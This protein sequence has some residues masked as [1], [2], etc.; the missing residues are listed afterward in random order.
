MVAEDTIT[1][2]RFMLPVKNNIGDD[3]LG[4]QYHI[5]KKLVKYVVKHLNL[6]TSFGIKRPIGQS[7]KYLPHQRQTKK[8]L[9][10]MPNLF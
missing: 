9:L 8:V 5:A 3:R 4:Y 6:R 1:K 7:V 10:T 2:Q